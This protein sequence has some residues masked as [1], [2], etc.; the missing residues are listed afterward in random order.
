MSFT[1]RKRVSFLKEA[2]FSINS[3][4]YYWTSSKFSVTGVGKLSGQGLDLVPGFS[5]DLTHHLDGTLIFL[6]SYLIFFILYLNIS[7]DKLVKQVYF[8]LI[9]F[10]RCLY[11]L[12]A[13]L[14]IAKLNTFKFIIGN[15]CPTSLGLMS[16][17]FLKKIMHKI[18]CINTRHIFLILMNYQKNNMAKLS[19]NSFLHLYKNHGG[20]KNTKIVFY[21]S[22]NKSINSYLIIY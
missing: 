8:F 10:M 6:V 22:S 16:N 18:F 14:K 7:Y 3:F 12:R 11:I 4:K 20:P 2:I 15:T 17:Y 1:R 19:V 5:V 13:I 9:N 21:F